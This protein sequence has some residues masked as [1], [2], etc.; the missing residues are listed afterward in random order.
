MSL[1]P[2]ANLCAVGDRDPAAVNEAAERFRRSGVFTTV[3]RPSPH[4]VVGIEPLPHGPDGNGGAPEDGLFFAEGEDVV[5][6]TGATTARRRR[7]F[8]E[9]VDTRMGSLSVFPGDFGALR[10]RPDG[11]IVAVRSCGGVVPMYYHAI[12]TRVT[13]ATRSDYFLRFGAVTGRLDPFVMAVWLAAQGCFPDGR[14]HLDGIK[15]VPRGHCLAVAPG[16]SVRIERYWEPRPTR[17]APFRARHA[18]E[19]AAELREILL[20]HLERDLDGERGNLLAL[21]G[22]V[23][24]SSLGAIAAGTLGKP[25]STVTL[26]PPDEDDLRRE[27]SYVDPLTES[28]GLAPSWR[29]PFS[30]EF[31]L[32]LSWTG[33]PHAFPIFHPVLRLLPGIH[34]EV[35]VRVLFGGEFADEIC[36]TPF[37]R[38]DWLIHTS[39]PD[40]LLG[41]GRLPTGFR[42]GPAWAR[43]RLQRNMSRLPLPGVRVP[44]FVRPAIRLEV[45]EWANRRWAAAHREPEANPFLARRVEGDMFTV[46]NWEATSLLGVRRAFPFFNREVLELA[47]R[48]HPSTRI[49]PGT[50][51]VL[52]RAVPDLV[53]EQNLRRGHSGRFEPDPDDSPIRWDGEVAE[54]LR[55]LVRRDWPPPPPAEVQ[56]YDAV[57]MQLLNHMAADHGRLSGADDRSAH[58]HT[59]TPAHPSP[60]GTHPAGLLLSQEDA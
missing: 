8:A 2:F 29:F 42:D 39:L 34:R 24:S 40:L 14:T 5:C 28:F 46:M 44:A 54:S 18:H 16:G 30:R 1:P 36:G 37:V 58:P 48:T 27:L 22:G 12:G 41:A 9:A 10:V 49:G 3:H 38:P 26:L 60:I 23:D 20:A 21:S 13:V 32:G 43:Y 45:A 47:F 56:L 55:D 25:V 57:F 52:R 17:I 4:W 6:G 15:V 50:K 31:L 33:P 35:P 51:A 59:R 11:S 53:P 7:D 19:A